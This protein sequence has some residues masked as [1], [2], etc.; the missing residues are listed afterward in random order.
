[1]WL[2]FTSHRTLDLSH[3]SHRVQLEIQ[4]S[5]NSQHP[6]CLPPA[7]F[8]RASA[9]GMSCPSYRAKQHA[10]HDT[11]DCHDM[12]CHRHKEILQPMLAGLRSSPGRKKRAT[13]GNFFEKPN[14]RQ[15]QTTTSQCY[16]A[17]SNLSVSSH[18]SFRA[19]R[20]NTLRVREGLLYGT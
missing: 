11:F 6:R 13:R 18:T 19:R 2:K 14:R 15:P 1:M 3:H 20:A 5:A 9:A 7:C 12:S 17:S 8:I 16:R 10:M 4:Q